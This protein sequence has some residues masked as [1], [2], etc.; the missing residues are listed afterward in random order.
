MVFVNTAEYLYAVLG[1][2]LLG[3]ATSINYIFRG[4]V[5]GMSGIVYGIVSWNKSKRSSSN[6]EELPE[7][8][9]VVGGMLL[10]SGIFF[11]IFQYSQD[12]PQY[13]MIPFGPQSSITAG[14]S[15]VGFA[16]A[17]LFVGFGTKLSN[18]CTSGHGLCGLARLS[19]RSLAAVCTFLFTAIAI[20]TIGYYFTLGALSD[21]A[22]NPQIEIN[23]MAS[24]NAFLAIGALLPVASY[25]LTHKDED[26]SLKDYLIDQSIIFTTG[27]VFGLGLMIS[28]MTRRLKIMRFLQLGADWDPSLLFVLASGVAVNLITFNYMIRVQ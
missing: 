27:I 21:Q 1:G 4:K 12:Y 17:G 8:L 24:A 16:L 11:D 19:P 13:G 7:K 25:F 3:I 26:F 22:L 23:N 28:G 20:G 2:V 5:T 10:I 9:T 18:G 6:L 15:F 14:T